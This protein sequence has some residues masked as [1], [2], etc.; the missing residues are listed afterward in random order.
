MNYVLNKIKKQ[1]LKSQEKI[2]YKINDDYITYKELWDYA[3]YYSIFLKRQGTSPVIIYGNKEIYMVIAILACLIAKRAYVPISLKTPISRIKKIIEITRTDLIITEH[4]IDTSSNICTNLE[5]LKKFNQEKIKKTTNDIAYIIFTSG[6][7]GEP[8]GVPISSNNLDNF[9]NWISNLEPLCN[10]KEKNVLN[11][12]NFSFD[13]SVADF[14]YALCNGHTLI[15]LDNSDF[16]NNLFE[17]LK[18]IN[19]IVST[20]TFIKLCLLNDEFNEINYPNVNCIYFCGEKL[21]IKTVKKIYESFPNI[22]IINAYGP[23]EATSAVSASLINKEMLENNSILPVGDV[24]NFATNIEIIDD[25]IVLK[26]KSVFNGYLNNQKGGYYKEN[27]INC[28]KTGDIGY[29]LNDKLYCK[30]RKDNQVKYKGY[31]IELDEIEYNINKIKGVIDCCC[32]AIYNND[33]VKTI[34]AY[35]VGESFVDVNYIK[36]NLKDLIPFYMIPKTISLVQKLPV[37]QNGKIDR[38]VL[39]YL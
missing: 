1:A 12:A 23:T 31:R 36:D 25:E 24:N 8:K 5:G 38:K 29:I 28:Y 13:L 22:K 17:L 11:Q 34:K 4:F 21:E 37:N 35:V 10:Y 27:N 30:G 7:T 19:V 14:Y 6:T 39:T 16:Y 15:A 26:G 9:V 2:A 33:I 20:P 18:E 3:T 32:V